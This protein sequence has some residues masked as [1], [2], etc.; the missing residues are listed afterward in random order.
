MYTKLEVWYSDQFNSLL[1][2]NPISWTAELA[3]F[4]SDWPIDIL[5]HNYKYIGE[6]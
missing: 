6:L 2:Y 1:I 3:F 5:H 4:I